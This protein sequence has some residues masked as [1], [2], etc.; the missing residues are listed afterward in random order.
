MIMRPIIFSLIG[1]FVASA[2]FAAKPAPDAPHVVGWVEEVTIEDV[3]L[4]L[5]AKM[6]TGAKTSSIDAE[7]IDIRKEGKKKKGYTGEVVV[8]SVTDSKTSKTN[9]FERKIVRFVRIKK[10]S[11]GY[12]RR[13]VIVMQFCV[14][15]KSVKEEVN[16]ANRENFI[17]PV[18][19]GRNMMQHAGIAIDPGRTLLTSPHCTA[20]E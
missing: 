10:K 12:L 17:Y 7:I 20:K 11:G 18:L 2:A 3:G 1:L 16:L 9:T 14:A 8:F 5:K 13:P 15:G 19:V 4:V 6:D